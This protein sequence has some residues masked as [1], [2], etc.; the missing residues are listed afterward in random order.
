MNGEGTV[1]PEEYE[2]AKAAARAERLTDKVS[3]LA[4]HVTAMESELAGLGMDNARTNGRVDFIEDQIA[5]IHE[6]TV[7]VEPVCTHRYYYWMA[8]DQEGGAIPLLCRNCE[9]CE[10]AREEGVTEWRP[11]EGFSE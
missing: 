5:K 10:D 1:S 9:K 4:D 6:H 7:A 3:R 11:P 8:G 2:R